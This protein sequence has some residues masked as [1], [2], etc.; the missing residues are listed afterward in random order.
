[1]SNDWQKIEKW[2]HHA[3]NL[4]SEDREVFLTQTCAGDEAA[5][6]EVEK[7][8]SAEDS[9]RELP[10]PFVPAILGPG[11]Q[12]GRFWILAACGQGSGG[13]V[14]LASD[15]PTGRLVAIKVFPQF[16]TSEE[17]RRYIKE[18][19]AAATVRHPHVVAFEEVGRAGDRDFLV[20]EYVDGRTLG[21]VIPTRGMAVGQALNFARMILEG[22]AAAHAAGI[23]HRDLKPSNVMVTNAG[24]IKVLDFGLAKLIGLNGD[25]PVSGSLST[26]TGQIVGTAC[27][28]SPEQ[29]QGTA[30]DARTDIF[31]FGAVLYEMLTGEKP[32][33]RGSLAGTLSAIL[34]DNPAPVRKLRSGTPRDLSRLVRRCLEKNRD[35]RFDSVHELLCA[36]LDCE[37]GLNSP[38]RR[39]ISLLRRPRVAMPILAALLAIASGATLLVVRGLRVNTARIAIEPR[40]VQLVSQHRYNAADELVHRIEA[41]VPGDRIVQD[42]KRDYRIVTSVIATPAGAEIAIK[43]YAT[44]QA[45]WR[46]M[47]RSPLQ[48]VTIPLG[49]LRWRVSAPG[50]R[51]REFAETGVLQPII[52]FSLYAA[53]GNAEDM[54]VVPAGFP[55]GSR[56]AVPEFSLDRYE[57]TNRKF[58]EFVSAGGYQRR[59]LWRQPFMAGGKPLTWEQA[60]LSFR[61]Q[62]GKAGP[63]GWELGQHPEG[64][65]DFPVVGVSW[66]EAAAYAQFAGRRLPTYLEWLRAARTEWLYADST[67]FSNFMGKGLAPVGSFGGL[68]RFGTYDLAGNCKEW[69]WNELSPAQRLT[70]GGAWDEAYY[71]AAAMDASA[72]WDRRANIGFRCARSVTP[73]ATSFLDPVQVPSGRDYSH[74]KPVGDAQFAR[75]RKLYDYAK[76]PLRTRLEATDDNNPHWRREKVTFDAPYAGGRITAYLFLPKGGKPPYQTVVYFASGIAYA[77]KSSEQLEMWFLEPLIRSGRAVLYPVLWGMY[78][79]KPELKASAAE[80]RLIRITKSVQDLRR[81][82]DYLETRPEVDSGKLAYFGFSAGSV[83]API[84]LATEPRF[85]VAALAVAGL[86]QTSTAVETDP[87][88]FAPRAHAPVLIMNGRYDL[89]FPLETSQKALFT[90]LG[91][92]P[93]NKKLVILEAGH[94]MVGFPASTRESLQWLDRYLGSVPMP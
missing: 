11:R 24:S 55:Y 83:Y 87:F 31:S 6:R 70:M 17:R 1:M 21:E 35:N 39:A 44:P 53:T 33:D 80:T 81:S 79:R 45:P 93:E 64:K 34:R 89:A 37:R 77:A 22:L 3:A 49:Y 69:L 84:V 18:A 88:Q 20:M 13:T 52:R 16:V 62:T 28:L 65:G 74:E 25:G 8:L 63:A 14:Y 91:A 57:V 92:A 2:F 9:G 51:T 32:F 4:R 23:I 72:P 75:I 73:P 36:I 90:V 19:Q 59:D 54:E 78:E 15:P 50:Y 27:Y 66:Y 29:A 76:T 61:D 41:T 58:R 47:G 86:D 82:L 7:L 43:D 38:R 60:M 56:V 5:R 85:K 68:D 48:N 26:A 12:F 67:L 46:T 10:G 40:I 42:F 30:V 71:A 94:A